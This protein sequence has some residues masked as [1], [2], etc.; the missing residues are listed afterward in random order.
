[1]AAKTIDV[2]A[3]KAAGFSEEQIQ[4][5]QGVVSVKSSP[6]A[7]CRVLDY[8]TSKGVNYKALNV[9]NARVFVKVSEAANV[10]KALQEGL[11]RA[12]RGEVDEVK[13]AQA[14]QE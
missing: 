3:L 10:I 11:E 12:N 2:A 14:P 9:A 4:K 1:M 13:K 8:T 6:A 7:K 5:I